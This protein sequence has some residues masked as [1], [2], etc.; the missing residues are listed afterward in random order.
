MKKSHESSTGKGLANLSQQ[1]YFTQASQKEDRGVN[2]GHQ[3]IHHQSEGDRPAF[4]GYNPVGGIEQTTYSRGES[5]GAQ[6]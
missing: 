6:N 3:S 1:Q 4:Y 5:G 2:Y